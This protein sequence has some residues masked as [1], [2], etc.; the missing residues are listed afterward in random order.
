MARVKSSVLAAGLS[1]KAGNVVFVQ[2]EGGV[3][4]RPY[5]LPHDPRTPAQAAVRHA[6]ARAVT[7]YRALS[8]ANAALWQDYAA[9]MARYNSRNGS[10]RKPTA[11]GAFTGLSAK[12]LQVNP[13]GAIPQAPPRLGFSGDRI[14]VTAAGEAGRIVFT[15][16]AANSADV[17]V[18]LLLQ[19]VKFAHQSPQSDKYRT[20][21][22][23]HFG[24]PALAASL[25]VTPGYYAPAYRF[26]HVLT[27]QET[28]IA[29]LPAVLVS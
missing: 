24:F 15:A 26:V 3:V 5:V 20:Q 12:F 13:A 17:R 23:A 29:P 7:A 27:G 10:A 9:G 14:T 16:S 4:A 6:F 19:P 25:E 8:P 1:G 2:T 21:A 22:F 18:E 28:E 11:Y